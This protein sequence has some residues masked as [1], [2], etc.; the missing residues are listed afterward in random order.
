MMQ[1]SE[2]QSCN[3][4]SVNAGFLAAPARNLVYAQ[5]GQ[6][7]PSIMCAGKDFRQAAAGVVNIYAIDMHAGA[8]GLCTGA[9]LGRFLSGAIEHRAAKA[10]GAC[11]R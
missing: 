8:M 1:G 4:R 9:C 11:L 2:G 7:T 3:G 6:C 5:V 10:N